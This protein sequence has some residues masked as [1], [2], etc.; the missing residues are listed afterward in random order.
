MAGHN[1][2]CTFGRNIYFKI[3]A[4][5]INEI[6]LE[7]KKMVEGVIFLE[8]IEKKTNPNSENTEILAEAEL[9]WL[10]HLRESIFYTFFS[11]SSHQKSA[12]LQVKN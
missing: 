11:E 8:F 2:F 9:C 7:L 6:E 10:I 12:L 4:D 3:G 5:Q 1:L